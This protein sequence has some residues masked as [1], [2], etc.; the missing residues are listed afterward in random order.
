MLRQSPLSCFAIAVD[1]STLPVS[2]APGTRRNVA[3]YRGPGAASGWTHPSTTTS[4]G[5][6]QLPI[7]DTRYSTLRALSRFAPRTV[8][9]SL[10]TSEPAACGS[11]IR[12][13]CHNIRSED[14]ILHCSI[15]HPRTTVPPFCC[16]GTS[17]KALSGKHPPCRSSPALEGQVPALSR[18]SDREIS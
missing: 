18:S 15:E 12:K 7:F 13:S 5:R 4:A 17:R 9:G 16:P 1:R 3:S 10:R 8:C 6:L 2:G 11:G 14:S